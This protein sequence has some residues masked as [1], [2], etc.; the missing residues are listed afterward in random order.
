MH[1]EQLLPGDTALRFHDGL[2]KLAGDPLARRELDLA[3]HELDEGCRILRSD[4]GDRGRP[5]W[6]ERHVDLDAVLGA[7][8][9][10]GFERCDPLGAAPSEVLDVEDLTRHAV[11]HVRDFQT[12][13]PV[14]GNLLH[15]SA[16]LIDVYLAVWPPPPET[17]GRGLRRQAEALER[18]GLRERLHGG[19]CQG[20]RWRGCREHGRRRARGRQTEERAAGH[21]RGAFGWGTEWHTYLL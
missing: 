15:L 16:D 19:A 3:M 14:L 11:V 21:S 5:G 12:A 20:S 13:E 6:S 2:R 1:R 17:R 9:E 7:S 18:G 8:L 10:G 4:G